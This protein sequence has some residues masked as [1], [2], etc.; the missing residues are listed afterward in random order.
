MDRPIQVGDLVVVV[1]WNCCGV[2]SG[3]VRTVKSF[4]LSSNAMCSK[5][6]QQGPH[7]MYARLS[8]DGDA[9]VAWLKRIPPLDELEGKY[10][11]ENIDRMRKHREPA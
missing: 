2:H 9:P 10:T 3:A 5:C 4:E 1:R 6:F 7:T 11:Q 8:P